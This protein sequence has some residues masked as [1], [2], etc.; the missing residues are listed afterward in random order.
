MQGYLRQF[1]PKAFI[2]I[3]CILNGL[4][5]QAFIKMADAARNRLP[6]GHDAEF[7]SEVDD[8]FHCLVCHLPLK[9]PVLT[10]CGHRFCRDCLEEHLR[11]CVIL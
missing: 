11:R 8:D 1:D 4:L 2:S 6:S 5:N 3:L 9:E 10:R 7:V